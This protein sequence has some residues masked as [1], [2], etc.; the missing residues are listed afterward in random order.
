VKARS[1]LAVKGADMWSPRSATHFGA[2]G[3]RP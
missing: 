1:R 3:A 2:R